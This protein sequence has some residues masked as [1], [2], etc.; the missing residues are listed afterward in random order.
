MSFQYL[1]MVHIPLVLTAALIPLMGYP[2]LYLPIHVVW[3]EL[4]IHPTALLV[5]QYH[6]GTDELRYRP[7]QEKLSFFTPIQTL[8][9][10]FTGLLVTSLIYWSYVRSLGIGRDVD[11][12]RAMAMVVLIVASG[13]V[14]SLLSRL[15]GK[16]AISV[17]VFSLISAAVLIQIP[18]LSSLL[19]LKPLHYDD[20]LVAAGSGALVCLPILGFRFLEV[21]WAKSA[22]R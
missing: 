2:I 12:A 4:I 9:I 3:L 5:F 13:V 19:N 18:G 14:T 7:R 6:P 15:R 16:A 21:A 17:T 1:L 11:H 10:A 8:G 20:W 22:G